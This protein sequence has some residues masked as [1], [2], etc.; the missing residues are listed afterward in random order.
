MVQWEGRPVESL[1]AM[2][3]GRFLQYIVDHRSAIMAMPTTTIR[4]I[5]D[6]VL[7]AQRLG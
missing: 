6:V 3:R 7:N 1:K 5:G 2:P 4:C